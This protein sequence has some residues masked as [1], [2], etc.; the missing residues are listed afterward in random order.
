[1]EL[2]EA[3]RLFGALVAKKIEDARHELSR[4][5][6]DLLCQNAVRMDWACQFGGGC[7]VKEV[8]GPDEVRDSETLDDGC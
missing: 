2:E 5:A 8:R 7:L 4:E 6:Y 1:M 3:K